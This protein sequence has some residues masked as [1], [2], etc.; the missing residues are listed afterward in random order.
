MAYG[1]GLRCQTFG[2]IYVYEIRGSLLVTPDDEASVFLHVESPCRT[3][4]LCERRDRASESYLYRRIIRAVLVRESRRSIAQGTRDPT[5]S[6]WRLAR[7][8][9]TLD[10]PGCASRGEDHVPRDGPACL[11]PYPLHRRL[12]HRNRSF[13]NCR[14]PKSPA[15]LLSIP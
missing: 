3:L 5:T 9:P 7:G 13:V 12:S 15:R 10:V 8:R 2:S 11:A 4:V 1:D 6:G 14:P